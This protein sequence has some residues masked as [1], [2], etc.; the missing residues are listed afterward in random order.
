MKYIQKMISLS[1]LSIG[2]IVVPVSA[3][4]L[5]NYEFTASAASS[6]LEANS[7]A[8]D[9]SLFGNNIGV[10]G[11]NIYVQTQRTAD[12]EAS[13]LVQNDP[14]AAYFSF[15]ITAE[16]GYELDLTSLTF[17]FGGYTNN[18]VSDATYSYTLQ[19]DL[20]G[21]GTGGPIVDSGSITIDPGV[22]SLTT[23]LQTI[24]LSGA[25]FQNLSSITF[26]LSPW[27]T[28][29]NAD[30]IRFDNVILNGT[31][32]AVPEPGTYALLMAGCVGAL[33]ATRR[34]RKL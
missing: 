30:T 16:S 1:I 18:A 19:T 6:D 24:T 33:V 2:L 4:V 8:S 34:R 7:I 23:E 5:A 15:T 28:L 22:T 32:S 20:G 26:R 13:S 10:G 3:D 9:V 31:V 14:D 12:D 27:T 21:L 25:S 11:S 17:D 29:D